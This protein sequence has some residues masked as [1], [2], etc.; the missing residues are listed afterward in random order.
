MNQQ[1]K[2]IIGLIPAAGKALRLRHLPFSKELYPIG[3][4]TLKNN[5]KIPKVASMHVVD[6]MRQA[7]ISNFYMV[8]RDGKWD[9]PAYYN[10]GHLF[11]INIGY[12]IA[13][14]SYG[15]PYSLNQAFPFTEGKMIVMGF[16]DII[17]SPTNAYSELIDQ[18]EKQP[19]TDVML[20]L[21]PVDDSKKWDVVDLN[22]QGRLSG[23]HIKSENADKNSFAWIIAGWKNK[24]TN[25]L[26][27]YI[28]SYVVEYKNL[29]KN[30]LQLSTIILAARVAGLKIGA[31]KFESG[32]CIDI[33]TQEGLEQ[34]FT[35]F[36]VVS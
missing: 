34:Y 16:P 18:M 3:M 27:S 10:N 22:E 21:F 8:I 19:E 25:F 12:L 26:N 4:Q 11:D 23:I 7:G 29:E 17:F 20:G 2:N 33:G 6:S 13:D 9:I 30:E 36:D 1:D 28:E 31:I 14:K 24:F 15:V 32:Q 5:E 35:T